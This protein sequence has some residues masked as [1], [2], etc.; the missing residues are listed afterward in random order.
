MERTNFIQSFYDEGMTEDTRLSKS[1]KGQLEYITTMHYIQKYLS[2][3]DKILEIGAGTGAYSLALARKGHD[4]TAI[5]LSEKNL[6]VLRQKSIG[7]K[8]IIPMQGDALNLSRLDDN[9]FDITLLFGPMYHLYEEKDHRQALNEAVRVT[10]SG[11]II[12]VA[13]LSIH[14][15][16]LNNYL[17]DDFGTGI[18]RNFTPDF[19]VKHFMEQL[20]TGFNIDEFENL[21]KEIP[22]DWITTLATDGILESAERREDFALSDEQFEVFCR[23]HL[24]HCERRELLGTSSHLLYICKKR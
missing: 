7:I 15:I 14:A 3:G 22:V 9:S 6:E 23:Y 21:F 18:K 5:E 16:M 1:R 17:R 10:K 2:A 19:Q 13:F 8:N 4:V 20:F 24:H 11:G 12:M